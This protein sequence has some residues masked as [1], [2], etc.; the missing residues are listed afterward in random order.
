MPAQDVRGEEEQ[1]VVVHPD[2][3]PGLVVLHDLI[4]VRVRVRVRVRAMVRGRVRGRVRVGVRV[5]RG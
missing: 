3:V 2:H 1:V 5:D 4:R